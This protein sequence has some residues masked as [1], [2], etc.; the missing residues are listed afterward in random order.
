MQKPMFID[1]EELQESENQELHI[2]YFLQMMRKI[3]EL[4]I[5]FWIKESLYKKKRGN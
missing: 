3:L 4:S 1:V 2:L 5:E